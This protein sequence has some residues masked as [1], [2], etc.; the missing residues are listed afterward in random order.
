MGGL[1]FVVYNKQKESFTNKAFLLFTVSLIIWV[2]CNFFENWISDKSLAAIFLKL[3]F[4]TA[5]IGVF[6]ITLFLINFPK[7]QKKMK[8]RENLIFFI[9]AGIIS[10]L[11]YS[12]FI[13]GDVIF[14]DGGIGFSFQPAFYVYAIIIIA[15]SLLGVVT[16]FFRMHISKEVEKKQIRLILFGFSVVLILGIVFNFILQNYVSKLFFRINTFSPIVLVITTGYAIIRYQLF[17]IKVFYVQLLTISI[18]A[19]IFLQFFFVQEWMN[20]AIISIT[21]FIA[22]FFGMLLIKSVKNEIDHSN[23]LKVANAKLRKMDKLK[24]EFISMAS[25]QLRTPLTTIKGF[26][27]IM[28]KGV[29]GSVPEGLNEPVQHIETANNRLIALVEDMMNVSQIEA[30]KMAFRF[31]KESINDL[32]E[33]ILHSFSVM[34]QEKKLRLELVKDEK[35]SEIWMDYG[36][37]RE[38]VSN[39]VDNA[40]KYTE[41]GNIRMETKK[42]EHN[43]QIIITDTGIGIEKEGFEFLF[44]KFSRGKKAQQMKKSGVGLGLYLGKKLVEAHHGAIKASSS[45]RGRGATFTITLPIKKY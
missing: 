40:I 11:A 33:E 22:V 44:D 5:P 34:T 28:K 24:S 8:F 13:I 20:F 25:H 7:P 2:N 14:N 29:Y 23:E 26:V 30:G 39:I 12:D 43:V 35:I 15:Y 36:K 4:I 16:L 19:L 21:F 3:D 37:I 17:N 18:W 32:M 42:T 41:K 38:V 31:K 6:F 1:G 27:S 45:G 9:P 10:L